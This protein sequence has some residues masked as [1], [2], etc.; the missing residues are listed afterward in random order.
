[1]S[2]TPRFLRLMFFCAQMKTETTFSAQL[3][4]TRQSAYNQGTY[5]V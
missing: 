4:K 1:M 3:T 2:L 5:Y